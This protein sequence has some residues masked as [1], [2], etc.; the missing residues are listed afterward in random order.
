MKTA[1][2][3]YMIAPVDGSDSVLCIESIALGFSFLI[4]NQFEAIFSRF[5]G[6]TS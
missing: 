3:K 1:V 2:E 5:V 4:R 6:T